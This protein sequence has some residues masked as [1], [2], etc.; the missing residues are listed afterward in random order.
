MQL[1]QADIFGTILWFVILFVFIILYPRIMLS[2]M[3]WKL[4]Q[5]AKKLEELSDKG[6]T[7]CS[8]RTDI[9]TKEMKEKINEFTDF[10]LVEPSSLD[11]YGIVQKID[12]LI[13]QTEDRFTEFV[14][15]HASKKTAVERQQ[16]NYGLR[17]AI[18]LRQLAKIVRHNVEL[19][20]K[21][22]NLQIAMIIQMQ[23]P[24]IEKFAESE[25]KGVESFLNGWPVG[26]SIGPMY[27]ASLIDEAVEIAPG[28]MAGH[29]KI[30]GR[31]CF[32][33]KA[34]GPEPHLG[35]TDEAINKLMKKHNFSRIITIDAGLKMEGE[36]SGKVA[37]GVG[38]AMGG[39]S[40]R[41]LIENTL[42]PKKK[43]IDGIIVKVGLFDAIAPM[44]KEVMD[45]IPKVHEAVVRSV[46]RV[47]AKEKVL[48][49]GVGNS[50]GIG[51]NKKAVEQV[52]DLIIKNDK[53]MKEEEKSEKKGSWI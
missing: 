20:K 50:S 10:F 22:K 9:H 6:N 39:Y 29:T 41:E 17:A 15:E 13:R 25:L 16:L 21:F 24:I 48:I 8:K 27:A 14:D 38:F 44:Q 2:Q 42:L 37:E 52:K 30:E 11:P 36:T 23:M 35:R 40:Q 46:K 33:L 31:E 5:S 18:G 26:D 53:K 34:K 45:S 1:L 4:E 3:I 47:K 49:I 7:I 19:A 51:D 32:V 43:P 12:Q 28:T